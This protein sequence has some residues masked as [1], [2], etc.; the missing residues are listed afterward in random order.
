MAIAPINPTPTAPKN[1]TLLYA[2]LILLGLFFLSF[3]FIVFAI[4]HVL[5]NTTD[6]S[7]IS[8]N[9]EISLV[10]LQGPI[11]ESDD[12]V[13]LI[14]HFR[15]SS[16]KALILRIDS[17][18]GVVAPSQEIYSEILRARQDKKI[19]VA[20]MASLAASG[21]YYIASA[22]DKIVANPG[23]L[24][25]SIGVIFEI[26]EAS[27]LLKKV[28]V[29]Y[30][31]VKSGKFK[32]TGSISRPM[33]PAEREY[34]QGTINEVFNQ[35]LDAVI[36]G[37]RKVFQDKLAK[38]LGKKPTDVTHQETKN[39]LLPYADGRVVTGQ[40]AY[41]LGLVDQMGDYEDAVQLTADLAGIKGEPTVR[42]DRPTRFEEFLKNMTPFSSLTSRVEN[43]CLMEYRAF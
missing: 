13:R 14:K 26:P 42:L 33:N 39:Y 8:S 40:T 17:P 43:G 24:T 16:K 3:C 15:K 1:N 30:Q 25:G 5:T 38:R 28:G 18:G 4:Q 29:D 2:M 34:I 22:C 10:E 37:R 19:V 12:L 6:T 11:Y 27:G 31:V 36:D 9:N 35:F 7:L 20:S 32:D 23:T 21:A 41:Q